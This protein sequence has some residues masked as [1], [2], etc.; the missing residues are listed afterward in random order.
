MKTCTP[1]ERTSSDGIATDA[2]LALITKVN[3]SSWFLPNQPQ[4][5]FRGCGCMAETP[6]LISYRSG[7]C[8]SLNLAARQ[9][10]ARSV[11]IA[12]CGARVTRPTVRPWER[13][14]LAQQIALPE[15]KRLER[16]VSPRGCRRAYGCGDPLEF[17]AGKPT[18]VRRSA[19]LASSPRRCQT[20]HRALDGFSIG[21]IHDGQRQHA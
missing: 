2:D 8:L 17:P 21:G 19:L 18:D 3:M 13:N 10:P 20:R 15:T 14:G 11:L 9:S 5:K 6:S 4:G 16:P 12:D 1:Q 7:S